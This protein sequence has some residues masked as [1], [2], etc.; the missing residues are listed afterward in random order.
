MDFWYSSY[1]GR[2]NQNVR[3]FYV[4]V[5]VWAPI[6]AWPRLA[7]LDVDTRNPEVNPEL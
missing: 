6:K 2:W 5:V 4:Y 3:Y 7:A 1:L